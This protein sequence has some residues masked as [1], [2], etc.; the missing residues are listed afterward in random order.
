MEFDNVSSYGCIGFEYV[1]IANSNRDFAIISKLSPWD[2]LPG[3]LI[4]REAGGIDTYFD[5]GQYNFLLDNKNLIVSGNKI[6]TDKIF[7]LIKGE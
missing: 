4:L 1:D 6:L 3:I 7:N 2:H 5:N